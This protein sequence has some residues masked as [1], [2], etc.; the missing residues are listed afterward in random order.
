LGKLLKW[1]EKWGIANRLQET[2]AIG[3]GLCLWLY[4]I[5]QIHV[6]Y[7]AL[8]NKVFEF[9]FEYIQSTS[10]ESQYPPLL[11]WV[12]INYKSSI[13]KKTN[14]P[15][16]VSLLVNDSLNKQIY[17]VSWGLIGFIICNNKSSSA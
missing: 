17:L 14:L 1:T 10:K 3:W 4:W 2:T 7:C 8:S 12:S 13:R 6:I 9:E 16:N 15:L 11:S 5:T